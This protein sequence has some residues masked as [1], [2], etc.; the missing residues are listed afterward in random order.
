MKNKNSLLLV[1]VMQVLTTVIAIAQPH[2]EILIYFQHG[3]TRE[4]NGA[5]MKATITSTD[6]TQ[7]LEEL[8]INKEDILPVAPDFQERDTIKILPSGKSI[9]RLN[10]AKLFKYKVPSG[11]SRRDLVS[12]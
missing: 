3:V 5:V 1:L 9:R 8:G 10:M 2:T 11:Q 12:A 7:A 4:N 6:L